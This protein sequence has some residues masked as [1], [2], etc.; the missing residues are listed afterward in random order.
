[1]KPHKSCKDMLTDLSDYIDGSAEEALCQEIEQHM[2]D[3][4]DC[5]I[6]VDTLEKTIYLYRQQ[7]EALSLPEGSRSRL[8]QALQFDDLLD[9]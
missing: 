1:M 5:Q 8:Y 7:D 3:C 6:F 2:E 4:P 9:R